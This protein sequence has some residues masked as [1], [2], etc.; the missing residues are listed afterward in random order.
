MPLAVVL[1]V[2]GLQVPVIGV[3]LVDEVGNDGAVLPWHN[4]PIWAKVGVTWLVITISM[5]AGVAH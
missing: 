5:V 4:G 2:A 1:I 3:A